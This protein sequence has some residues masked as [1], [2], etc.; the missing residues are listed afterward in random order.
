MEGKQETSY[1]SIIPET[2]LY[3]ENLK[4]NI[5][6]DQ[7]VGKVEVY[8]KKTNEKIGESNIVSNS[9]LLK[10]SL[11]EYIIFIIKKFFILEV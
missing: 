6:I 1:Y 7:V 2:I 3:N 9:Q 8:D 4:A 10:S 5:D 11:E